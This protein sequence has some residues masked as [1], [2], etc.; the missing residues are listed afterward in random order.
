MGCPDI[1]L[2]V[3]LSDILGV[4]INHMLKGTV[5]TNQLIGGNLKNSSY[6]VCTLCGNL[7]ISTG[8]TQV[9]CCSRKIEK[10]EAKKATD[11][12]KL[13]VEIDGYEFYIT[14]NHPS[15]KDNY[16]SFIFK[17]FKNNG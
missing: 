17:T 14:S 6:H 7:T 9:S 11:E 4:D 3:E 15:T 12:Q 10:L 5:E 8:D 16:I 13:N 1:T 2:I